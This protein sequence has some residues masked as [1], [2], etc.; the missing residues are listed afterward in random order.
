M[1]CARQRPA[2][3]PHACTSIVGA[4]ARRGHACSLCICRAHRRQR[5]A[6]RPQAQGQN[7]AVFHSARAPLPGDVMASPVRSAAA[8][9]YRH[10]RRIRS[11]CRTT[12]HPP[13]SRL[14]FEAPDEGARVRL[15]Q[16]TC[17]TEHSHNICDSPFK[18]ETSSS[19]NGWRRSSG[20]G[21]SPSSLHSTQ[22]QRSS[23]AVAAHPGALAAA[24]RPCVVV[25]RL[26]AGHPTAR[27]RAPCAGRPG[28]FAERK[29]A[30]PARRASLVECSRAHVI[31]F[32]VCTY[33][34]L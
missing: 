5:A 8:S 23:P 28:A 21:V 27:A 11:C 24:L 12:T 29:T 4:S 30:G 20:A 2:A 9:T 3:G 34:S 1:T 25:L 26:R 6:G 22:Q 15:F 18:L 31:E 19:R 13:S 32:D 7:P 10:K 33:V 16:S 14:A 17:N